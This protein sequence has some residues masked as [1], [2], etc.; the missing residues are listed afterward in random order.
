MPQPMDQFE[1][2]GKY[3]CNPNPILMVRDYE[4]F[5]QVLARYVKDLPP[6][7]DQL[8]YAHHEDEYRSGLDRVEDD[9]EHSL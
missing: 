1:V 9:D 3:P 8:I 4:R 5:G 7:E 6:T 2:W